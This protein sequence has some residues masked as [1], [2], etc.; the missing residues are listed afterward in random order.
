MFVSTE[1]PR[2][3]T[4]PSYQELKAGKS[5]FLNLAVEGYPPPSYQWYKNGYALEEVEAQL[6]SY[7]IESVNT[8]HSGTYSCEVSNI[9]GSV[10]WLEATVRVV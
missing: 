8:T 2:V 9:A 6:A 3:N 10:L 7:Y 5:L 1:I 4:K